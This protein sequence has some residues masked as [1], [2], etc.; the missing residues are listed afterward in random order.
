[1]RQ[2]ETAWPADIP[3][4]REPLPKMPTFMLNIAEFEEAACKYLYSEPVYFKR[5]NVTRCWTFRR[6]DQLKVWHL[7][8]LGAGLVSIHHPLSAGQALPADDSDASYKFAVTGNVETAH[9]PKPSDSRSFLGMSEDEWA[10][11]YRGAKAAAARQ[12]AAKR[13]EETTDATEDRPGRV[14]IR[15][16]DLTLSGSTMRRKGRAKQS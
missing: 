7:V 4:A 3:Y 13:L 8:L 10:E 6:S 1:M 5:T 12:R 14:W 11:W 15:L 2:T 9:R 16:S